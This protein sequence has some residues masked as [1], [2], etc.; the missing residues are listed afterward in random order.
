MKGIFET[1]EHVSAF[2]DP[3]NSLSKIIEDGV[4]LNVSAA[5]K[6]ISIY[7]LNGPSGTMVHVTYKE[8]FNN[9]DITQ[10]EKIGILKIPQMVKYFSI[11]EQEKVNMQFENN[12]FSLA[13]S[14]GSVNWKT[15]DS[16][17]IKESPKTLKAIT[18]WSTVTVDSKTTSKFKT[19][20]KAMS[21]LSEE[22]CVYVKGDKTAGTV[23]FIVRAS[24]IEINSFTLDIPT[25]VDADFDT[26][27]RKDVLE[28]ALNTPSDSI[29]LSFSERMARMECKSKYVDITYY[30]AKKT[31]K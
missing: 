22:D 19:L 4:V 27:Y 26:F 2:T 6:T 21:V 23:T 3:L 12:V 28:K 11:L 25:Q 8:L 13:N 9:F 14:L 7:A 16:D 5:D 29:M 15:A 1:K 17:M 10:D 24:G 20:L 31:S 30:I 18:W